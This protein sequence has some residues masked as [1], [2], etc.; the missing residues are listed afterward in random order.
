M[1][2][3]VYKNHRFMGYEITVS[4]SVYAR[5]ADTGS[6]V[7]LEKSREREIQKLFLAHKTRQQRDVASTEEKK[8]GV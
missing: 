1:K 5:A 8:A 2:K 7:R 3:F 4:G 6:L